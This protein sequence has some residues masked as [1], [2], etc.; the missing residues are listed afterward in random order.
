MLF[1][2]GGRGA[3][4]TATGIALFFGLLVPMLDAVY[5]ELT[6]HSEPSWSQMFCPPISFLG[7]SGEIDKMAMSAVCPLF[8]LVGSLYCFLRLELGF[9]KLVRLAEHRPRRSADA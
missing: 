5:T 6:H 7:L 9:D 2:S 3:R 4:A 1:R 8:L